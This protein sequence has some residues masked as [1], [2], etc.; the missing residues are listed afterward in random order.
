MNKSG[1]VGLSR[2]N[3]ET[4]LHLSADSPKGIF[5]KRQKQFMN[6]RMK[7]VRD[8]ESNGIAV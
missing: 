2:L 3:R 8:T 4:S 7:S 1:V 5:G 6:L